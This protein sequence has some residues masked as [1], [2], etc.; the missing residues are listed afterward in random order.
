MLDMGV[1]SPG[2]RRP[3][4]NTLATAE[5]KTKLKDNSL[6]AE[7]EKALI[8]ICTPHGHTKE[9][10]VPR[11]PQRSSRGNGPTRDVA[12][13]LKGWEPKSKPS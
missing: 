13:D 8:L 3:M 5:H 4:K 9:L 10:Q 6:L 2:A 7:Q 11:I 1:P 12:F